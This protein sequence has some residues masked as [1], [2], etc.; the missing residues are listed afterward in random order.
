[1]KTIDLPQLQTIERRLIDGGLQQDD[2]AAE[3]GCS[4]QAVS[5]AVKK[6][7]DTTGND[8]E[9][10]KC[11]DGRYRWFY[12]GESEPLFNH[13]GGMLRVKADPNKPMAIGPGYICV[14]DSDK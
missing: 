1:M 8:A 2:A 3:F 12:V 11:E 10:Y 5:R 6:L 4:K 7:V 14:L 13:P 9:M